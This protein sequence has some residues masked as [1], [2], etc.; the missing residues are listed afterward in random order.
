MAMASPFSPPKPAPYFQAVSPIFGYDPAYGSLIGVAWFSYPTGEVESEQTRTDVNLVMR[1]GP[2]GSLSFHQQRPNLTETFGLYVGIG[3]NNFYDYETAANS[4]EIL[5]TSNQLTLSGFLTL[6]KPLTDHLEARIGVH[7]KTNQTEFDTTNNGY[8]KTGLV[9]DA[10][11]NAT[12][13]H[14]GYYANLNF[15]FQ[16]EWATNQSKASSAQLSLDTRLFLPINER[17]TVA[18]RTLAQTSKG[19]GLLSQIGGSELLRGYLGGQFSGQHLFA[20]QSE[21]RFPLWSFINGVIFAETARVFQ[22]AETLQL[23]SSGLG[24]RFGLPPDQSMSVRLDIA[25]NDHGQWQS[26]VNFNQVF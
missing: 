24:L 20:A 11:D 22:Q 26:Y 14:Q 4:A 1:F 2:H 3:I 12:N 13:S 21:V 7:G 23:Q 18:L 10:R 25:L 19:D 9:L 6:R 15:R 17:S 5:N 8:L 16:P